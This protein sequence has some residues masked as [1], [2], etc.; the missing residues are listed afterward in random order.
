M[1]GGELNLAW[2]RAILATLAEYGLEEIE[3]APGSRSAPL[4]LASRS[5]PGLNTR[6]HLDERSAGFF[7]LGYGRSHLG[8]GAVITTPGTAGRRPCSPPRAP[9]S[10]ISSLP[11]SRRTCPTFPCC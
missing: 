6:V 4:V 11:W 10:P 8:P 7:A 3:I 9:R 5:L 1:T 2:A